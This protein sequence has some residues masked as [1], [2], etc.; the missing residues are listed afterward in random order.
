MDILQTIYGVGPVLAR[1]LIKLLIHQGYDKDRFRKSSTNPYTKQEIYKMLR[2][3]AIY[4]TLPESARVYLKYLPDKA[5]PRA[6]I[7]V[8]ATELHKG[9]TGL[10]L[11]IAGSYR[12]GRETS[13]DADIVVT[14]KGDPLTTIRRGI[15]ASKKVRMLCI[16][17]AGP[18]KA[19]VLFQVNVNKTKLQVP[20]SKYVVKS[21]IFMADPKEYMYMLLYATGSGGFNIIMRAQAKRK[22]FLLNQR[23]LYKNG[24]AIELKNEREI[25]ERLGMTYREPEARQL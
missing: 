25:F 23:G 18:D 7:S 10:K 14:R 17:A 15:A 19:S 2:D 21:D 20:K 5:I 9:I 4:D 6:V 24:V 13:N 16:Y 11:I 3:K 8:L 1:N 22:G 12:R